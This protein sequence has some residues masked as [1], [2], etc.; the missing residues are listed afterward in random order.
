MD[1]IGC[2]G[3]HRLCRNSTRK[4]AVVHRSIRRSCVPGAPSG[5]EAEEL[6]QTDFL[7]TMVLYEKMPRTDFP[8]ATCPDGARMVVSQT[9]T[10]RPAVWERIR[11]YSGTSPLS[12][13]ADKNG[14]A[15]V[16][17]G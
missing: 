14:Y 12:F 17:A 6:L 4:C 11:K 13:L 10:R 15:I 8:P 1:S 3:V 2:A 5:E 9:A 16:P 7:H